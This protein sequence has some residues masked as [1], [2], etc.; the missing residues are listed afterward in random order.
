VPRLQKECTTTPQR[1]KQGFSTKIKL[2]S[3]SE[4]RELLKEF[5]G[6][7]NAEFNSLNV[8]QRKEILD[9]LD[10]Q[11]KNQIS[12]PAAGLECAQVLKLLI[13]LSR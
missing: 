9:L 2:N 13:T 3:E 6:R 12:H 1:I 8:E 4:N 10:T 11:M 7:K 5:T